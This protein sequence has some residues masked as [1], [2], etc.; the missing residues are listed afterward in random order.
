MCWLDYLFRNLGKSNSEIHKIEKLDFRFLKIE[1]HENT[2]FQNLK[3]Q[4][5]RN[6]SELEFQNMSIQRIL[7]SRSIIWK[8][9]DVELSSVVIDD[10]IYSGNEAETVLKNI[11]FD[12]VTSLTY[13]RK[14]ID[15]KR[16]EVKY[17]PNSITNL[18]ELFGAIYTFYQMVDD[19]G[20]KIINRM[21][22]RIYFVSILSSKNIVSLTTYLRTS[23]RP[24]LRSHINILNYLIENSSS[25]RQRFINVIYS[26]SIIHGKKD[27]LD[28]VLSKGADKNFRKTHLTEFVTKRLDRLVTMTSNPAVRVKIIDYSYI[29][30]KLEE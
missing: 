13:S 10:Q 21:R 29:L 22:D 18:F 17:D 11:K 5:L 25:S 1:N 7:R 26:F 28:F 24:V 27:V 15:T 14:L 30:E 6:F 9:D 19:E 20:I 2:K 8:I 12:D 16:I 23:L 4:K 3:N